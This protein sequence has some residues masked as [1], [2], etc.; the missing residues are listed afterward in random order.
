VRCEEGEEVRRMG[1]EE[2]EEEDEGLV[3]ANAMN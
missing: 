3:K 2:E 1:E